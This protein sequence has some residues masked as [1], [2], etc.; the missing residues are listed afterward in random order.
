[1]GE[2]NITR[3]LSKAKL[4]C[5]ITEIREGKMVSLG[6]DLELPEL[7]AET[8]S[9]LAEFYKEQ[10]QREIQQMEGKERVSEGTD[11]DWKE[12]W[13]LSQFWYSDE[14]A[15][16]L[17]QA[18]VKVVGEEGS[19]ACVSAPTLYRALKKLGKPSLSVTV[20]EFDNRFAVYGSDFQFYDYKSPL[21]IDRNLREKFDLVF[22]DPPFLSEECLT[23]TMVTVKFLSKGEGKVVL[24][25]GAIM[26]DLANRLGNLKVC[27]CAPVHQNSLSNPFQCF[28]SFDLDSHIPDSV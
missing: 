2:Y 7:S 4:T 15:N 24:C 1:M 6:E 22:A 19:V 16:K 17:A 28:S 8:F 27:E 9:A 25:T 12:D 21:D 23:K 13:Q 10:E 26:A 20:F 18:I 14:T 5:L 11:I 3:N